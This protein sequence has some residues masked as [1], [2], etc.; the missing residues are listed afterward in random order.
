MPFVSSVRGSYGPQ[1]EKKAATKPNISAITGGSI[2]TAGG[3]RIHT[4]TS[5]G[6]SEFDM[7]GIEGF[8]DGDNR[9]LNVEYLVIGGGGGG[10]SRHAGGGGSGGMVVST[11]SNLSL[12][13]YTITVGDGA[14]TVIGDSVGPTGQPSSI[15]G[16]GISTVTA[17]GGGGGSTWSGGSG[18]SGGSGGGGISGQMGNGSATQTNQPLNGTGHGNPG[19]IGAYP[20]PH[21]HGGGGGGAGSTGGNHPGGSGRQ[22]SILGTNYHWAGGGGGG[23]WQHPGGPGGIGGGGG[24]A[25]GPTGPGGGSALNSGGTPPNYGGGDSNTFGGNG[26]ANTGSGGG[27]ANQAPSK[28]GNG[29]SGIVVIRYLV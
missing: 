14:Q 26:G 17:F 4:F 8:M 25:G 7:S 1:S 3:Y 18:T 20:G 21:I 12:G 15:S 22:N 11:N 29:G 5:V 16:Q 9:L 19:G 6:S 27:G 10:G 2:T 23:T 24:G 13:R 28:G